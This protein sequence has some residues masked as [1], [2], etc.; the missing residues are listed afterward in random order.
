MKIISPITVKKALA[1]LSINLSSGWLGII[2]ISPGF[3]GVTPDQ[4]AKLILLNLP[5]GIAALI[6]GMF[7]L[8]KS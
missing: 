3:L 8:E 1:E 7:L 6:V 5:A 2:L 4:Y